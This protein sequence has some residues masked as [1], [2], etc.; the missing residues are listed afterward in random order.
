MKKVLI[1]LAVLAIAA[2]GWF[3]ASPWWTLR[4]MREAAGERD[5]AALSA[6]VDYE[7]LR[8]DL[9]GD[10]R[11]SMMAEMSKQ[12]DNP[13][14][15]IG[16][17]IATGLI[18]PLVEAAISPEGVEAMF[19][20]QGEG[21]KA[22]APATAGPSAPPTPQ[23]APSLAKAAPGDDPVVERVSLDEFRVRGAEKDSALIFRRHGL[24]WKLSAVDLPVR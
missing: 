6:Y 16:M 10:L 5:S 17:A 18:D 22:D 7:A 4:A 13:F 8:T 9:K 12:P 1:V 11:R 2:A 15:S 21:E 24:G 14:A 23:T 3:Y 19:A 20:G